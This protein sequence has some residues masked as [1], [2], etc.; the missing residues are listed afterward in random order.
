ML[1]QTV[2]IR[3]SFFFG[4]YTPFWT[5]VPTKSFRK[6]MSLSSGRPLLVFGTENANAFLERLELGSTLGGY[7][8]AGAA[9]NIIGGRTSGAGGFESTCKSCIRV[10]KVDEVYDSETI[11]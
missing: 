10:V 3:F 4:G 9:G 11:E 7:R 1:R 6:L 2:V 8:K 5:F